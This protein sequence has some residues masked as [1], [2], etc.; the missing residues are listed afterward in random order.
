MGFGSGTSFLDIFRQVYH[1]FLEKSLG[2][3]K[4]EKHVEFAVGIPFACQCNFHIGKK[5]GCWICKG[6]IQ[7][8]VIS[9]H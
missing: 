5:E 6:L 9:A 1:F 8:G 2:D 4:V 3:G 7:D